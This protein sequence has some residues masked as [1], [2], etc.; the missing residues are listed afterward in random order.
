M[1][2]DRRSFFRSLALSPLLARKGQAA[3]TSDDRVRQ[4]LAIR[5]E[6]ALFESRRTVAAQQ[7]NG[8]ESSYPEYLVSFSKG[9]PHNQMGEVDPAAYRTLLQA[10]S[11]G[12]HSDFESIS[13]GSGMKLID[14][15]AAFAFQLEGAD[16][17]CLAC[18]PA[19]AFATPTAAAE[20]V[21]LYWHALARDIPF[22]DYGSSALIA[23]AAAELNAIGAF[24]GP[25]DESGTVSPA[26][27]FRA[28]FPGCL[29]G[30][31]LSQFLL[32]PLPLNSTW[33]DQR[34]R[35]GVAGFDYLNAYPEWL[36]IQT[37]VPPF[38]EYMFDTPR[39]VNNGRFL[40]EWVH[41]DFLY[42]GFHNAALILMN[43]TPES[44]LNTNQYWNPWN[45]YK[46]SKVQTGFATFGSPHVCGL[47]G[48]TASLALQAAW[49]QK[50]SVHR[51]LRPEAFGGRLHNNLT[52]GA[53]Y[54]ISPELPN[55]AAVGHVFRTSGNYLLPQAFPEGSPLHPAY[56]SGHATVSGACS[57]ILKAFFDEN[58][59]VADCVI[60]SSDGTTLAPYGDTALT[61]GGEINKLA[62][63]IAIGR[64]FAGIHYRSDA[65]EGLRLGEQVGIAVLEDLV[66]T[67]NEDYQGFHFTR[68]DGT[69][70]TIT[71]R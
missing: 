54:P 7:D 20:M 19:P 65:I 5:E 17:H 43:V 36:Q 55:S 13:R 62:S 45:P 38:R 69:P 67:V 42:Q 28:E 31:Y 11:S 70:V 61:V 40:G 29:D 48:R 33:I 53:K 23:E 39:F 26:T 24:T 32:K 44:I 21:E 9:L 14:P 18:P 64:N 6:A 2:P 27:I 16:S 66:N 59:I 4:A 68:F 1:R 34:F 10:I 25:R 56:P 35:A 30:P 3:Q 47:L 15:Q 51:R 37:G 57:V 60:P 50:W 52:K 22:T 63:N 8:D 12:R 49:Y 46:T 71:R 58:A 41:Y